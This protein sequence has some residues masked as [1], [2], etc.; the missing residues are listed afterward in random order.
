MSGCDQANEDR[1]HS[2]WIPYAFMG[3]I[4]ICVVFN[5]DIRY[6]Q[7]YDEAKVLIIFFVSQNNIFTSSTIN[8]C[9]DKST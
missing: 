3:L 4:G 8:I 2:Y 7:I 9:I 6:Y 5:M 1:I